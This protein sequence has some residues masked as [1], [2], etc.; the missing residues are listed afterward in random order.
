[1]ITIVT[2][3]KTPYHVYVGTGSPLEN[4]CRDKAEYGDWLLNAIETNSRPVMA[5]ITR[6][7]R[8]HQ[9]GHG[10]DLVIGKNDDP[11]HAIYIKNVIALFSLKTRGLIDMRLVTDLLTKSH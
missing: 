7:V 10:L 8:M 3:P 4:K 2:T 11:Y 9:S 6:I 1:M 5:V